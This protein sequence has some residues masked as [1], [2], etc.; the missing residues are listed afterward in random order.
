MFEKPNEKGLKLSPIKN[1][2]I[3]CFEPNKIQSIDNKPS[4]GMKTQYYPIKR[5]DKYLLNFITE[6]IDFLEGPKPDFDKN[7][8]LCNLKKSKF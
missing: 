5:D 8:A 3:F 4:F 6:I 2:G 1:L 7:C